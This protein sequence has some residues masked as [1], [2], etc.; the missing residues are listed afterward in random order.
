MS[1]GK[2]GPTLELVDQMEEE[3]EEVQVLLVAVVVAAEEPPI[4]ELQQ[5]ILPH[6]LSS[7]VV[8]AVDMAHAL[9]MAVTV[10]IHLVYLDLLVVTVALVAVR[11]HLEELVA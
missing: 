2:A 9:Q 4:S 5:V 3:P 1:V 10:V 7:Q 8:E 6:G 11:N